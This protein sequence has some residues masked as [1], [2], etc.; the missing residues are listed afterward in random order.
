MHAARRPR[1]PQVQPLAT[2]RTSRFQ[3]APATCAPSLSRSAAIS[4]ADAE[5]VADLVCEDCKRHAR[6]RSESRPTCPRGTSQSVALALLIFQ[7]HAGSWA[8]PR[9]RYEL[10]LS[11]AAAGGVLQQDAQPRREQG[12][13]RGPSPVRVIKSKKGSPMFFTTI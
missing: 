7:D 10:F 13:A 8:R 4:I 9:R 5:H 3:T 1:L 2:A 12:R 6:S 11:G